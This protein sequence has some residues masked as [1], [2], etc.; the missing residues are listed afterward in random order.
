M[1]NTHENEKDFVNNFC[2]NKLVITSQN[3][4]IGKTKIE[5]IEFLKKDWVYE[6]RDFTIKKYVFW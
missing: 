6:T 2:E 5:I 1:M 4:Q 3:K